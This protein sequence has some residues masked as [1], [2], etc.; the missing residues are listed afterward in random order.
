[1]SQ[2]FAKLFGP[3]TDQILVVRCRGRDGPEV[4]VSTVAGGVP[5]TWLF[6]FKNDPDGEEAADKRFAAIGESKARKIAKAMREMN[7]T[8]AAIDASFK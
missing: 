6:G 1:M 4:H 7:L 3:E 2:Q 8:K 5:Q